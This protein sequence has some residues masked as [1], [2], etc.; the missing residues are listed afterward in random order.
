M[1]PGMINQ[2][3]C[4]TRLALPGHIYSPTRRPPW[5]SGPMLCKTAGTGAEL[6]RVG[7]VGWPEEW[8]SAF[9]APYPPYIRKMPKTLTPTPG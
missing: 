8:M 7:S 2:P 9:F 4:E 6:Y 1:G 3:V 5:S